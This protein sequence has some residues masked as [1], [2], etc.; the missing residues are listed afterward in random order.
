MDRVRITRDR[1]YA[2]VW[3]EPAPK[4]AARYGISSTALA[5]ICRKLDVPAPD[6]GYWAL[7][8]AGRAPVT[9]RL[10]PAGRNTQLIH[11]IVRRAM[12]PRI[13]NT[14]LP[15]LTIEVLEAV[16]ERHPLTE[17][18]DSHLRAELGRKHCGAVRPATDHQCLD[19][20][21]SANTHA[22]VLLIVDALIRGVEA[23]AHSVEVTPVSPSR[24]PYRTRSDT[25]SFTNFV[26]NGQRVM[27][28]IEELTDQVPTL[29]GRTQPNSTL[30]HRSGQQIEIRP[31]G[32]LQ[33]TIDTYCGEGERRTWRDGRSQRLEKCLGEVIEVAERVA[34]RENAQADEQ[35][36][37]ET[38]ARRQQHREAL[39]QDCQQRAATWSEVQQI[40][41]FLDA[42]VENDPQ[43]GDPTTSRGEVVAFLRPQMKAHHKHALDMSGVKLDP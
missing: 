31:S 12:P 28:H 6:R 37:R 30:R 13:N 20:R 17:Q 4:V 1:L 39:L 21:A 16:P 25:G 29:D 10:A 19:V 43:A 32:R 5:K 24:D 33:L 3:T 18:L 2:E 26:I 40:Q 38:E 11:E 27:F 35:R 22:R 14:E 23:R 42:V 34:A 7:H 8:A 36:R 41:A 15:R 9:P